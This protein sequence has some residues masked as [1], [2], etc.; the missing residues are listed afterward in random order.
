M[1]ANQFGGDRKSQPAAAR[2]ARGLERLEQMSRAFAGTPGPVSETSMMA[3]EPSRRP[4]I[5]IWRPALLFGRVSSAWAAL[6]TR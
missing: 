2:T 5:R 1:G 4:V 6:R 3:T